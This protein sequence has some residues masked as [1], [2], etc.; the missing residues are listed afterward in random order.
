MILEFYALFAV[1]TA[2]AAVFEL[3]VPVLTNVEA[4]D[5]ENTVIKSRFLTLLTL[6]ILALILAPLIFPSCIIPS[7]GERFR[8]TLEEGFC[9][10]N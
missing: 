8:N 4:R 3:Y 5:P 10:E 1:T 6:I 7:M 2:V 9:K